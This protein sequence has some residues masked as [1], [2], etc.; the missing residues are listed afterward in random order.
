MGLEDNTIKKLEIN[1]IDDY[2]KADTNY[3]N[4]KTIVKIGRGYKRIESTSIHYLDY[5][6]PKETKP[7]EKYLNCLSEVRW[8]TLRTGQERIFWEKYSHIRKNELGISD[9]TLRKLEDIREIRGFS[10]K[11][12]LV[13]RHIGLLF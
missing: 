1:H 12:L 9:E 7:V 6:N 8:E 11:D 4:N 3:I 2:T 10:L 13:L 5:L